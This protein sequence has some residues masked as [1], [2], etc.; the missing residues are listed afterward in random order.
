MDSHPNQTASTVTTICRR[1]TRSSSSQDVE[2]LV[3]ITLFNH[4]L[5]EEQRDSIYVGN[6]RKMCDTDDLLDLVSDPKVR[7]QILLSR[8]QEGREARAKM[9]NYFYK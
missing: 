3:P 7:D 2:D 4:P 8:E 5:S 6:K 1:Q 9:M